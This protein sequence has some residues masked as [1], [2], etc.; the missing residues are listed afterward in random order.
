MVVTVGFCAGVKLKA[1]VNLPKIPEVRLVASKP[2][3]DAA[4]EPTL[5]KIPCAF[6]VK[7]KPNISADKIKIFHFVNYF[8]EYSRFTP[9]K[10]EDF[11]KI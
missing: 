11:I 1:G 4:A 6:E 5:L 10:N 2:I 7:F 9:F 8:Y 3:A